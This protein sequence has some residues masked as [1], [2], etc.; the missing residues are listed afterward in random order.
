MSYISNAELKT[1]IEAYLGATA[2]TLPTKWDTVLTTANESAANT[3]IGK[4]VNRGLT[5][6]QIASWDRVEEFNY[7]LGLYRLLI[8]CAGVD[9]PGDLWAEKL[10]R[11]E[12]DLDTVPVV[13][14]GVLADESGSMAVGQFG[15]DNDMFVLS[16]STDL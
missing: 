2:S 1:H 13:L 12:D 8:L 7:M 3:I 6:A 5:L 15:T 4:L 9:S 16:N 10:R 14:S 11:W